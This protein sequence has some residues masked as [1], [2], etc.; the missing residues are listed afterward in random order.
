MT[1]LNLTHDPAR[2]SWVES[3]NAPGSDFPIQNLPYGVFSTDGG[4]RRVGVAIGDKILD[5]TALEAAGR[6]RPGG[7]GLVF[8]CGTLNPFMALPQPAWSRTR[9]EIADLLD[10]RTGTPDLPL[11]SQ[12]D[13]A[14]PLRA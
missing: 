7:D 14:L 9:A 11:V 13:A 10:A 8:D 12:S 3:A 6:L 2:E 4:A 1:G 5:L